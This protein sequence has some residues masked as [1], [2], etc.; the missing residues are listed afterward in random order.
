MDGWLSV[1]KTS[2]RDDFDLDEWRIRSINYV[3]WMQISPSETKQQRELILGQE[4]W[5]NDEGFGEKGK[6]MI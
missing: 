6:Q 4:S 5:L 3:H 1:Y 2:V